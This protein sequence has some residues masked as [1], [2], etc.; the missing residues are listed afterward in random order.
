LTAFVKPTFLQ[1]LNS[2]HRGREGENFTPGFH[3]PAIEF[4]E[5]RRFSRACG[6]ADIYGAIARVEHEPD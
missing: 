2:A 6:A 4:L 3:Q 1:L 5:R